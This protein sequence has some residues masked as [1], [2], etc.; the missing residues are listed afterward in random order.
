MN[1]YKEVE[2]LIDE[3]LSCIV[4]KK[5]IGI[6]LEDV[7]KKIESEGATIPIKMNGRIHIPKTHKT[8]VVR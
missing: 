8:G 7:I 2:K 3:G 1:K 6:K 5:H 4:P